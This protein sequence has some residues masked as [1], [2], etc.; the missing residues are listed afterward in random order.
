M[1]ENTAP[2]FGGTATS[3]SVAENTPAGRNIG[4]PVIATDNDTDDKLTYSLGGTNAASF[5]IV[6]DSG[7]LQTKAAL[8]FETKDTYSVTVTATDTAGATDE[9]TVTINVTDVSDTQ[10]NNIGNNGIPGGTNTKSPNSGVVPIG[11]FFSPQTPKVNQAP[12]FTETHPTSRSV[13]EGTAANTDIGGPVSATDPENDTLTYSLGG[14][15]RASF[16]IETTTGQLKTKAKLDFELKSSYVVTV[17][18]S[19]G[20]GG[21][22]LIQV[23]IGVTDVVE[24]PVTDEDHQVVV[25]V[26]PEEETEVT[27]VGADGTV[28]FPE[29]TRTG[30]FFVRIDTN[31]DNCDWDSLDDP[32]AEE[33]QACI[34]VEVFDTEGNPITG[35][36]ILDPAITIAVDLDQSDIGNGTILGFVESDGSWNGVAIT[37]ADDGEGTI[38]VS[39]SG[40]SGPGTYAVGSNAAVIQ[41]ILVPEQQQQ[42]EQQQSSV[43]DSSVPTVQPA[44]V[45]PPSQD[46]EPTPTATATPTPTPAPTATPEPTP[47]A[48]PEPTATPVATA[49]PTTVPVELDPPVP[50]R[51]VLSQHMDLGA[52]S[53]FPGGQPSIPAIPIDYRNLKLWPIILLAIGGAMELVAIG[54]FVKEETEDKNGRINLKSFI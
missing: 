30:P 3:R 6:A 21:T 46:P 33:L 25:L 35:D 36:N 11:S 4:A 41:Q 44:P 15:D 32:P 26:D 34:K 13:A 19:D 24:V 16:S 29:D 2:D 43:Q 37:R 1:V 8:D 31:P 38:T 18:V 42:S 9:I 17:S 48:V 51:A 40:I 45:P 52:A 27:T 12:Q 49:T 7:Q 23:N 28:T 50:E 53:L 10:T 22:N 54:L 20:N 5:D 39:I 47:T 14:P